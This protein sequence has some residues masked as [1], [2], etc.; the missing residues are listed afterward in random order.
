MKK[1]F[2]VNMLLGSAVILAL[3]I[4]LFGFGKL[5]WRLQSAVPNLTR[6]TP[7]PVWFAR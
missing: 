2:G 4:L 1:E 5:E 3:G 7:N 6:P